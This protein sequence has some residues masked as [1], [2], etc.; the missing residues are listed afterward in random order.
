MIRRVYL[1]DQEDGQELLGEFELVDG[2]VV[3]A[4]YHSPPFEAEIERDGIELASGVYRPKDG[5][6]FWDAI[7]SLGH[8][9]LVTVAEED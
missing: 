7:P 4:T 9:G 8:S 5:V 2:S 3:K 6:E 1:S